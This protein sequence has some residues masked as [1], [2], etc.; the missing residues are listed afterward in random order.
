MGGGALPP[1]APGQPRHA[2]LRPTGGPCGEAAPGLP[3]CPSAGWGGGRRDEQLRGGWVTGGGGP[4]GRGR[5][6]AGVQARLAAGRGIQGSRQVSPAR[7]SLCGSPRSLPLGGQPAPPPPPCSGAWPQS[8]AEAGLRCP[9]SLG[10][11]RLAGQGCEAGLLGDPLAAAPLAFLRAARVGPGGGVARG[12]GGQ[13]AGEAVELKGVGSQA[14]STVLSIPTQKAVPLCSMG[15]TP[16]KL[17]IGL[18]PARGY[19]RSGA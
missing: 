4:W 18:Q 8:W 7:P 10:C 9:R 16:R 19:R 5:G 12:R 11:E 14:G 13:P 1:P 6:S 15:L 3:Q 17:R 2:S